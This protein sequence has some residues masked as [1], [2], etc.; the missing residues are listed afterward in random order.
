MAVRPEQPS[1]PEES[2]LPMTI[3]HFVGSSWQYLGLPGNEGVLVGVDQFDNL[4]AK[5]SA[6]AKAVNAFTSEAVQQQAFR[7]LVRSFLGPDGIEADD[8]GDS[9]DDA[10]AKPRPAPRKRAA[11]RGKAESAE[12]APKAARRRAKTPSIVKTLNLRPP[13]KKSF[14]DFASEKQPRSHE[15]KVATAIHYLRNTLTLD[16]VGV[17]HI[18]TCYR[19]A[20]GWRLPANLSNKISVTGSTKGWVDTADFE[21]LSLTALGTNLVEHDLPRTSKK[22]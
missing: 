7:A 18:Y 2:I 4:L 15:E 14:K 17:D 9:M 10:T 13:G 20:E 6:I 19:E 12:A 16:A 3:H 11:K 8:D 21:N 22:K 5:T 1:V